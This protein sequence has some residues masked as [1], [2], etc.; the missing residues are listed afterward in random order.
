MR[1]GPIAILNEGI[2]LPIYNYQT[3]IIFFFSVVTI[4]IMLE[5]ADEL[6]NNC[7]LALKGQRKIVQYENEIESSWFTKLI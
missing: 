5:D 2:V 7:H 3:S 1:G 6:Y 4:K